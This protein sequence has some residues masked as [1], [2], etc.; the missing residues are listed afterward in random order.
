MAAELEEVKARLNEMTE[1]NI[2]LSKVVS[3]KEVEQITTT[4]SEGMSDTQ[5]EKFTK[6]VEA[7]DYSDVNEFR[8]KISIIKETYFADKKVSEVKVAE[9]QLLSESVEEPE[10]APY[11]DPS[12]QAY[13]STISRTLNK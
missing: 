13:V 6:L 2:E 9:D 10:K 3:E 5:K 12:M 11:I 4:V 7:I 1:S 8:K